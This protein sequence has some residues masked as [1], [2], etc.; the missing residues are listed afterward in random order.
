MTNKTFQLQTLTCP[1]CINKITAGVKSLPGVEQVEVLFNSS[2]VK[3]E[4][5]TDACSSDEIRQ[6]IEK[7]GY[8]VLDEK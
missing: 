6:A 4:C 8:E 5:T 1:S 3:V 7:L 2:R